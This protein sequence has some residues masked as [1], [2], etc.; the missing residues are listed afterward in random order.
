MCTTEKDLFLVTAGAEASGFCEALAP[1]RLS[2]RRPEDYDC[3]DQTNP[4]TSAAEGEGSDMPAASCNWYNRAR[5][6]IVHH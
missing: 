3:L 2:T 5:P 1:L 4:G 6:K